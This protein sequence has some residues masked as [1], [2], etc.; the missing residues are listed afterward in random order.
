M[1]VMIFCCIAD[2]SSVGGGM[3]IFCWTRKSPTVNNG[4]TL[5]YGPSQPVSP[6]RNCGHQLP[7][8]KSISGALRSEH[9]RIA[10]LNNGA[11]RSSTSIISERY[12][13][14]KIGNCTNASKQPP[15][16]L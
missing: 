12:S 9:Q 5:K 2:C 16:G 3:N 4:S 10:E 1:Y 8:E 6:N 7:H 14:M 15:I 13:P 11:P